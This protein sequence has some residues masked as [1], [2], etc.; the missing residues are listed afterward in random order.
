MIKRILITAAA[1]TAAA[2]GMV[3]PAHADYPP[4]CADVATDKGTYD[5]SGNMSVTV[6]CYEACVGNVV[7]LYLVAPGE[8]PVKIGEV[9]I[10]ADGTGTLV[11]TAPIE[12]ASYD[13]ISEGITCP[14]A[15]G[16]FTVGRLPPTGSES[17]QWMV[18][19]TALVATGAGFLLIAFRRRRQVAT[20]A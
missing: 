4:G 10:A 14:D 2:A 7:E 8:E 5:P 12:L 3:M 16:S 1:V 17:N 15:I 9:V 20:A 11:M 6:S 18:T 19:A 13:I